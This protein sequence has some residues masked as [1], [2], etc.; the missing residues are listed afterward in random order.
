MQREGG[1]G[2]T[3]RDESGWWTTQGE[4]VENN[5]GATRCRQTATEVRRE[6][7]HIAIDIMLIKATLLMRSWVVVALRGGIDDQG[8]P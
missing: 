1:G 2:A 6:G 3:T 5:E 7:A 4:R 8:D